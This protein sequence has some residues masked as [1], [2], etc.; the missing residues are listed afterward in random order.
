[1]AA[2]TD[3]HHRHQKARSWFKWTKEIS[4]RR[5][6]WWIMRRLLIF[7][8]TIRQPLN[9]CFL[10]F[11]LF[12]RFEPFLA[13]SR[14]EIPFGLFS[15]LMGEWVRICVWVSESFH[16][17]IPCGQ[18]INR[19]TFFSFI[20]KW[21]LPTTTQSMMRSARPMHILTG[22][23]S[24]Q[25]KWEIQRRSRV[26]EKENE[27]EWIFNNSEV[28]TVCSIKSE[29]SLYSLSWCSQ[30]D[31]MFSLRFTRVRDCLCSSELLPLQRHEIEIQRRGQIDL[32]VLK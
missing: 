19:V 9:F 20:M 2:S 26:N 5:L 12:S 11:R 8:S 30:N 23:Y 24:A 15:F 14:C 10:P 25:Y 31:L 17:N 21:I 7:Y 27:R 32:L 29:I 1:M 22:T 13:F 18:H 3:Q 6:I 28:M 16:F 4:W